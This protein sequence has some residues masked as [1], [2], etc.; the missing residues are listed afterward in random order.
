MGLLAPQQKHH[1]LQKQK[2]PSQSPGTLTSKS[3][4]KNLLHLLKQTPRSRSILHDH[5]LAKLSQQLLLS[6]IQPAKSLHANLNNQIALPMRVQVWHTLTLQLELPPTLRPFRHL[7]R[8]RP[9]QR[10]DLQL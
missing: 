6:L 4:T 5:S 8:S 3:L 7:D 10:L 9:I 1:P 2:C